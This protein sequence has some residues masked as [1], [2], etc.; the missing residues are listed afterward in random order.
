MHARIA[1]SCTSDDVYMCWSAEK[2]WFTTVFHCFIS[3]ARSE[4]RRLLRKTLLR[5][6]LCAQGVQQRVLY[7]LAQVQF[8]H[9]PFFLVVV[10]FCVNVKTVQYVCMNFLFF[11]NLFSGTEWTEKYV[12]LSQGNESGSACG[13]FVTLMQNVSVKQFNLNLCRN[14]WIWTVKKT[15]ILSISKTLKSKTPMNWMVLWKMGQRAAAMEIRL[16]A[17][18]ATWRICIQILLNNPWTK[19]SE[20]LIISYWICY[21]MFGMNKKDVDYWTELLSG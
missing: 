4:M 17:W 9:V 14:I 2:S 20:K 3:V 21:N 11:C 8:R 6:S 18:S 19:Q 13:S 12:F 1:H 7:N 5:G 16:A 10:L 15:L